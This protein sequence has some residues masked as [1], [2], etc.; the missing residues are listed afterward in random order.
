MGDARAP[1][2]SRLF[3]AVATFIVAG[4]VCGCLEDTAEIEAKARLLPGSSAQRRAQI[5]NLIHDQCILNVRVTD[6]QALAA[7][8]AALR[9]RFVYSTE[10][11]ELLRLHGALARF[12]HSN[13]FFT[14]CRPTVALTLATLVAHV[15]VGEL[16]Q[17][18]DVVEA[19][20]RLVFRKGRPLSSELADLL[21]FKYGLVNMAQY[22][23]IP[24]LMGEQSE[25]AAGARATVEEEAEALLD[26]PVRC[27][28]LARLGD[29]MVRRGSSPTHAAPEYAA[30]MKAEVVAEVFEKMGGEEALAEALGRV[31]DKRALDKVGEVL[32]RAQG[33]SRGEE[34]DGAVTSP[35][36]VADPGVS[37]FDKITLDTFVLLEYLHVLKTLADCISSRSCGEK[38]RVSVNTQPFKTTTLQAPAA[39]A[40]S[41]AL[42]QPAEPRPRAQAALARPTLGAQA[43][44]L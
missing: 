44:F 27:G 29:F 11:A 31:G 25:V 12:T 19:V 30:G 15:L 23:L 35:L 20:E 16:L 22:K 8:L 18:A 21:E 36:G 33:Y 37:P 38:V 14:V 4:A 32:D 34:L 9:R 2:P 28:A 5:A 7:A 26:M 43:Q 13:S 10:Q 6:R 41:P 40:K 42:A 3:D 39:P 24:A 17:A 1:G